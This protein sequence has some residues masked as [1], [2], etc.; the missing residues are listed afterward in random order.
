MSD[1]VPR[2]VWALI[3]YGTPLSRFRC[4]DCVCA[5]L[6]EEVTL[7]DC[8]MPHTGVLLYD[9]PDW[10][11]ATAQSIDLSQNSIYELTYYTLSLYPALLALDMSDNSLTSICRILPKPCLFATPI[12]ALESVFTVSPSS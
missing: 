5:S 11:P 10:L 12:A 6:S 9:I 2:A 8:T 3:Q 7:A 1:D 4:G